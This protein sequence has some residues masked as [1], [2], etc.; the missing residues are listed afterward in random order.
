MKRRLKLELEIDGK[1]VDTKIVTHGKYVNGLRKMKLKARS[2][3]L[4]WSIFK[5][6]VTIKKHRGSSLNSYIKKQPK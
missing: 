6:E 2:Q 3:H 5:T 4:P 1:V